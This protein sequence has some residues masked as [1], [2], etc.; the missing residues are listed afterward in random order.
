M[1]RNGGSGAGTIRN[2]SGEI[3]VNHPEYLS[4]KG[5]KK[6]DLPLLSVQSITKYYSMKEEFHQK[7]KRIGQGNVLAVDHVS[8]EL[9]TGETLSI[10]GES[11]CGKTTLGKL[12]VRLLE[13]QEGK[14]IFKGT[15]ILG[16]NNRG[17][18]KIR[19]DIQMI[20]QDPYASLN[21]RLTVGEIIGEGLEI[22]NI[23]NRA[24]K[25]ALIK[26]ILKEVGMSPGDSEKYPREFSGG[27]RQRINIARALVLRPSLI[28][29]D[30][31]VS[32]LDLSIKSQIMNL[33]MESQQ[34]YNFSYLLISHD[35][36]LVKHF[37][38]R[39]AIMYLGR[40]VEMADTQ[41]LFKEPLHIY[42]RALISSAPRPYPLSRGEKFI[43][44]GEVPSPSDPPSGCHFHPRCPQAKNICRKERPVLKR[45]SQN[46]FLACHLSK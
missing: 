21:P 17:M 34:K 18:R 14:I 41:K 44:T 19:R 28:I 2:C 26:L 31:P 1:G 38:S 20:F 45:V 5:D 9:R 29:A 46:H 42:T 40:I 22:N 33:L 30:E 23:H 36:N 43:L 25:N 27:Q 32:A 11:G 3:S 10:I 7:R 15:D 13:P 8:F 35:L 12:I 24:Q 39:T 6:M 37:S 4:C 16:L